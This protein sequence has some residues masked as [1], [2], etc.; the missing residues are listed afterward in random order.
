MST[1]NQMPDWIESLFESI[2]SGIEFKG[3]ASMERRYSTPEETSWGIDLLE[4][5]QPKCKYQ[6]LGQARERSATA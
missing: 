5:R 3:V 2:V 6:S 4:R 1:I